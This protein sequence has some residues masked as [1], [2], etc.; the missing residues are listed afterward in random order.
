MNGFVIKYSFIDSK[1]GKFDNV[2]HI[3][4]TSEAKALSRIKEIKESLK[5]SPFASN[6]EFELIKVVI[7]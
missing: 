2:D 3:V 7:D 5:Q 4:S 6:I 1:Y